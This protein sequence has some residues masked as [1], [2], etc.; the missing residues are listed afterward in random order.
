MSLSLTPRA[1]G[2]APAVPVL[3]DWQQALSLTDLVRHEDN[4]VRIGR[5]STKACTRQPPQR[6][7]LDLQVVDLFRKSTARSRLCGCGDG[8]LLHLG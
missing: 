3:V 2:K 1:S 7:L 8:G 6:D 4:H 5:R